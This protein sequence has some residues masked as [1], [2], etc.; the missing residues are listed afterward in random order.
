MIRKYWPNEPKDSKLAIYAAGTSGGLMQ[1]IAF[2][3]MDLL[4]C[5]LQVD[6]QCDVRKYRGTFDCFRQVLRHEGVRG[7]YVGS[8]ACFWREVPTYGI[9]FLTY[10]MWKSSLLHY[11]DCVE[12]SAAGLFSMVVA[13]GCSGMITWLV[14][15]PFDVSDQGTHM[16][17]GAYR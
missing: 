13:G 15:Y 14:C 5:R 4:K 16:P 2:V 1:M 17:T 8:G 6:G 11:F 3:P 9:Y 10:E 12:E 7:L